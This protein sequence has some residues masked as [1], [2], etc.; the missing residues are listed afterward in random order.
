M[1]LNLILIIYFF[2]N[3]KR[4]IGFSNVKSAFFIIFLFVIFELL[5]IKMVFFQINSRQFEKN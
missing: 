2:Q 4:E 5:F 1:I 3:F